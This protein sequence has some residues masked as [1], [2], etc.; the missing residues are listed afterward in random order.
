MS[1]RVR[2]LGCLICGT[3]VH[4]PRCPLM[5]KKA[6]PIFKGLRSGF[7][8]RVLVRSS[9]KRRRT[10]LYTPTHV[11]FICFK[12]ALII[13]TCRQTARAKLGQV[14]NL[15]TYKV[16]KIQN[17]IQ[18]YHILFYSI[19]SHPIHPT[20]F[21]S[22]AMNSVPFNFSLLHF[23]SFHFTSLYFILLYYSVPFYC[24]L[25]CSALLYLFIMVCLYYIHFDSI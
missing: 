25:F 6:V 5:R 18:F 15:Q 21:H 22:I 10:H 2:L 17:S 3:Q 4:Q 24:I 8:G 7:I 14:F 1:T 19:S 23:I 13:Q 9:L 12:N 20:A 11:Y 16:T